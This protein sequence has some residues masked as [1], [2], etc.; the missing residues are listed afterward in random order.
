MKKLTA[1][2]MHLQKKQLKHREQGA[3]IEMK[4]AGQHRGKMELRIPTRS[5]TAVG[6]TAHAALDAGGKLTGELAGKTVAELEALLAAG[7]AGAAAAEEDGPPKIELPEGGSYKSA[8]EIVAACV[9]AGVTGT[10]AV[11]AVGEDASCTTCSPTFMKRSMPVGSPCPG[12]R[13]INGKTRSC[14]RRALR[15]ASGSVSRMADAFLLEKR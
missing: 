13:S 14:F 12:L 15:S 2:T 5:G 8:D 11:G 4:T 1:A 3:E 6:G 7:G 10:G 9:A